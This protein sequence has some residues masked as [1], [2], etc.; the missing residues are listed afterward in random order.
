MKMEDRTT[1]LIQISIEELQPWIDRVKQTTSV[2]IIKHPKLGLVMMRAMESVHNDVF[3]VGEVLVSECSVSVDG[4]LGYG[5]VMS[6]NSSKAEA[7]AILDAVSRIQEGEWSLFYQEFDEW[8]VLKQHE[9]RKESLLHFQLI[10][11]TR[12]DFELMDQEEEH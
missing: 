12:V 7:M 9:L 8:L 10:E 4:Q 11:R 3:N 1:I 5:I 2:H 6:Q